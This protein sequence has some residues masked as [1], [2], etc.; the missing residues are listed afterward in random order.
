MNYKLG[1]K[2]VFI[3]PYGNIKVGEVR[4]VRI[5]SGKLYVH[6]DLTRSSPSGF[7]IKENPHLITLLKRKLKLRLP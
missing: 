1:D 2:V 7:Y 4:P 6:T 5:T 3:Q